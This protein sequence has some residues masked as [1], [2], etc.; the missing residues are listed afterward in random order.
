MVLHQI[1]HAHGSEQ[2]FN[3]A[4]RLDYLLVASSNPTQVVTGTSNSTF[5]ADAVPHPK[6][7][8]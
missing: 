2:A 5:T 3:Y 7:E 4:L 8:E 1:L 6:G